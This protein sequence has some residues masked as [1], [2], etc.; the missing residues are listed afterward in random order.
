MNELVSIIVP[1]YKVEKYL[2]RC[3]ES[4]VHQTYDFLEII[5]VDDGSPD[6]CPD[7]CDAWAKKDSRIRVIH[8]QNGGLSDARNAGLSVA[9]GK[10]IAFVDS[11]DWIHPQMYE[12]LIKVAEITGSDIVNCK[13]E[14]S[15]EEKIDILEE[16]SLEHKVLNVEEALKSLILEK[17]IR[18]VVWNKIYRRKI[19]K[20]IWFEKGKFHEDEFWTY[21]VIA[22]ANHITDLDFIGYYY[23]Q[24]EDSIIGKVYS[25]KRLDV[26]EAKEKRFQF[27]AN[28][29]PNLEKIAKNNL[30]DSLCYTYQCC[31]RC[32]S[33]EDLVTAEN[34]IFQMKKKYDIRIRDLVKKNNKEKFWNILYK[35]SFKT[36]C[37]IRNYLK[38][39]L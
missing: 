24:R 15:Y 35:I 8:K 2:N 16:E 29:F 18:Q 4:I 32:L 22:N 30:Y 26:L 3:I 1:I 23:F 28:N 7:I 38:I 21:R 39:G 25:L 19:L 11:D 20:G 10:Y 12:R 9:T 6:Q 33:K 36:T 14:T 13:Y 27:I 5:L 17:N 31:L 34:V 37:R